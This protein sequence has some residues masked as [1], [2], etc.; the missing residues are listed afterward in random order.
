MARGRQAFGLAFMAALLLV[1]AV[2]PGRAHAKGRV[3]VTEL[4]V[5]GT[6]TPSLTLQLQDG[7]ILGLVSAGIQVLDP[8][9]VGRRLEG[10]PELAGCDSSPCLKNIGR[11]LSVAYIVRVR[12]EVNGNTYKMVAR[13]F[14]TDG[15]APAALP[16]ATKSRACD[17]CT[18]AEARGYM[19]KLADA[20]RPDLEEQAPAPVVAAPHPTAAPE[21]SLVGPLVAAMGGA[22]AVATG[23]A[24][25]ATLPDCH[26]A[27]AT[28]STCSDNR[29]RSAVAGGLV[30]AGVVTSVLGVTV[31]LS[32]GRAVGGGGTPTLALSLSF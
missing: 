10:T 3:A 32:R 22:V 12:V 28:T 17:V 27:A 24:L 31:T 5:E 4:K 25:L 21:A 14:S 30:G 29:M 23:V 11:L 18:V 16:V 1:V 19:L 13:L 15:A 9:D 26:A 20:L 7:F 8:V 6:A 2:G